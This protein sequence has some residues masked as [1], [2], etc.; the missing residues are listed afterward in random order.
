MP[1]GGGVGAAVLAAL[2]LGG[3]WLA[4]E[5]DAIPQRAVPQ[6]SGEVARDES[7]DDPQAIAAIQR[8]GGRLFLN[9]AGRIRTVL[10]QHAATTDDHLKLLESFTELERLNLRAA[11]KYGPGITNAGLVHLTRFPKLNLLEVGHNYQIDDGGLAV[12]SQ[13]TSLERLGLQSTRITNAGLPHLRSL[14]RLKHLDLPSKSWFI[15]TREPTPWGCTADGIPALWGLPLEELDGIDFGGHRIQYLRGLRH[16]RRWRGTYQTVRDVDLVDLPPHFEG[17][18]LR[19]SLTEGW[20]QTQ[21]LRML[22][23]FPQIESLTLGAVPSEQVRLDVRGLSVLSKLPNLKRLRLYQIGD[24]GLSEFPALPKLTHLDLSSGAVSGPGL[25]ALTRFPQLSWL[26]LDQYRLTP[27][28][29]SYLPPLPHLESLRLNAG[30]SPYRYSAQPPPLP[31]P[32]P[33]G[34]SSLLA[35]QQVP[36]LKTLWMSNMPI[37]DAALENLK[38]VP[39][40]ASLGIGETQVTSDGLR[41]LAQLPGLRMIDVGEL[42]LNDSHLVVFRGLD[43]LRAFMMSSKQFSPTAIEELVR[44]HPDCY[45]PDVWCCG[46]MTYGRA[47][48]MVDSFS[49]HSSEE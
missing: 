15:A 22:V 16:L 12:L 23:R 36:H 13:I 35:L 32:E 37:T 10:W 27:Q 4:D 40:L 20:E 31:T 21:R 45:I 3:L 30:H 28:S 43:S 19:V 42:P 24:A 17:T 41:H 46:C 47:I 48:R 49:D 18:A 11:A 34:A 29:L 5:T 1:R 6:T 25:A 8:L 9:D 7:R 2:L 14:V 39:E 33:W 26:A 38:Y 44:L